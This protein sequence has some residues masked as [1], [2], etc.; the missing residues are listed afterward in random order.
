MIALLSR[1]RFELLVLAIS[2]VVCSL[3]LWSDDQPVLGATLKS[4]EGGFSGTSLGRTLLSSIHTLE[5]RATDNAVP[6][7]GT[8]APHPDVLVAVVDEKS[9]QRY[10]LWPWSRSLIGQALLK[11]HEGGVAA[12]GMDMS[13]TD[14]ARTGG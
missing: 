14:P 9:A 10:G 2:L 1:R 6:A 12:I 11:L 4:D 8:R 5:G 3:H 7:A 13:F